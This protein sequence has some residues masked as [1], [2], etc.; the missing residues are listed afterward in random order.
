MASS[1]SNASYDTLISLRHKLT[2]LNR[3]ITLEAVN[4]L[5]DELGGIFMVTKTHHY[6]QKNMDTSPAPSLSQTTGLSLK[7]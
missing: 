4:R 5:K 2:C 1:K 6:K 3:V 7:T